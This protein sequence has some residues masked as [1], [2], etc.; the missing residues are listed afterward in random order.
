MDMKR[1]EVAE[2]SPVFIVEDVP[3]TLSFYRDQLGFKVTFQG[4]AEP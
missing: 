3:R 2:V 1:S 4:P